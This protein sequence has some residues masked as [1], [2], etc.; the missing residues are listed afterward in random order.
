MFQVTVK[1]R[2]SATLTDNLSCDILS[3]KMDLRCEIRNQFVSNLSGEASTQ[4]VHD[5]T[6]KENRYLTNPIKSKG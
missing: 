4:T 5:I 6:Q 3:H 1:T 2:G